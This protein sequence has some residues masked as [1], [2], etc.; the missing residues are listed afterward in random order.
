MSNGTS[1]DDCL[2][3][4]HQSV[5]HYRAKMTPDMYDFRIFKSALALYLRSVG[6]DDATVEAVTDRAVAAA[7]DTHSGAFRQ[8]WDAGLDQGRKS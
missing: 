5:E 3:H 4:A 8:G 7:T 6:V 2:A 1:W